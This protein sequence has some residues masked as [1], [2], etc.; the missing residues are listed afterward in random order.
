MFRVW[1]HPS[2]RVSLSPSPRTMALS[3]DRGF[4][5]PPCVVRLGWVYV[6]VSAA[7]HSMSGGDASRNTG[8]GLDVRGLVRFHIREAFWNRLAAGWP[9]HPTGTG[10]GHARCGA[11]FG[12]RCPVI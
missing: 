3:Q 12:D 2:R 9:R 11:R 1:T 6:T 4:V 5:L 8:P 10:A 7:S